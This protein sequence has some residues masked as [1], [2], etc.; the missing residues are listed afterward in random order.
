[1]LD[2]KNQLAYDLA[3]SLQLAEFAELYAKQVTVLTNHY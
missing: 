3:E 2:S 1:M